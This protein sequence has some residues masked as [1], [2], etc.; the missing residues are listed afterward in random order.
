MQS[1]ECRPRTQWHTK[2]WPAR[3]A[4]FPQPSRPLPVRCPSQ[5]VIHIARSLSTMLQVCPP[6]RRQHS[7][8]HSSAQNCHGQS[9]YS[10]FLFNYVTVRRCTSDVY[11]PSVCLTLLFSSTS[12]R[13][14]SCSCILWSRR[15][16]A[17]SSA[18]CL[19]LLLRK[20]DGRLVRTPS[21]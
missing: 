5:R 13:A 4:P 19:F 16:A 8:S 7:R 3:P 21:E 10:R 15:T 2:Q 17:S 12:R 6:S 18:C 20:E 9:G 14:A 1:C 11:N